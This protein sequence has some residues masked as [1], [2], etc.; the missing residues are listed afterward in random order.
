MFHSRIILLILL[1]LPF[2]FSCNRQKTT[3]PLPPRD[4]R[5]EGFVYLHEG[6]FMLDDTTWFPL[7]LNYKVSVHDNAI[8]PAS[9]Y[10][11]GAME[12]HFKAIAS[13]GSNSLRLCLDVLPSDL[14]TNSLFASL[15]GVLAMAKQQGLRVMLLTRPP[16]DGY[17]IDY[18]VAL[19][20]HFANNETLWAYD[21]FNEPLYFDSVATRQKAGVYNLVR[22]WRDMMDSYAP[23]QLFTIGFAEPIEVFRWDPSLLPVDFVQIHTY[24]P[25]R[26]AAEMYWYGHYCGKPW[27]VGETSLPADGDSVPYAWQSVF[28]RESY[29]CAID[30]GAIGYGWWEFQDCLEGTN[31]EAWYSGL[32]DSVGHDKPAA[33]VVAALHNMKPSKACKP[34]N[35][36]NM[37]G[38]RNLS[39]IG[40]VIDAQ[41]RQPI[42][43][44]VIRGW[45]ADW[46]VGLNTFSDSCG[47]FGLVSNDVCLHFAVSAPGYETLRFDKPLRYD[48]NPDTLP[49][50]LLEYQSI[51]YR[52]FLRNEAS[53]LVLDT[54]MF[55]VHPMGAD[56]GDVVLRKFRE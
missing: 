13:W 4:T 10:G 19:L 31:F 27:M 41:T 26:V 21:F 25:L 1:L 30:N 16:L 34:V 38:Y 24:H 46:S 9:Y 52:H 53:M 6:R 48:I 55:D 50:R 39:A 18:T 11:G 33:S 42:E 8:V 40:R 2:G 44:A 20:R 49:Q 56:M 35:Y 47:R 45:N 28:M 43:G 17:W 5:T 32:R 37:L 14:D 22:Q 36:Y 12:E 3:F 54:A 7:M 23:H 15:D 29:Q 51:D